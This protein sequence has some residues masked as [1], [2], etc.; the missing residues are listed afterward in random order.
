MK[1]RA[2]AK[3]NLAL[4][5]ISKDNTGYHLIKTVYQQ[6]PL[7]D[8]IE[9]EKCEKDIGEICFK[10]SEKELIDK[11]NNTVKS[12]IDLMRKRY[13]IPHSYSVNIIKNIPVGS[14]LGGGSSNAASII[15]SINEI[16]NLGLNKNILEK[17]ASEIGMD[18]PFFIEGETALGT[19]YGEK[20][21]N[22]PFLNSFP[23]WNKMYK[24]LLIPHKR[25]S[26]K[27]IYEKVDMLISSG[28]KKYNFGKDISK[29][30]EMIEAF[31]QKNFSSIMKNIHNDFEILEY[32]NLKK[33]SSIVERTLLCGSGSAIMGF[34]KNPFDVKALSLELPNLRILNL[35]P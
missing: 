32:E 16:E 22:L 11:D 24:I 21:Q 33:L 31:S 1:F 29:T 2:Y 35:T 9:I 4:D 20:I 3:I 26:T 18:V 25:K 34:S 7:F 30:N 27:D 5:I 12:A 13:K 8:E 10:E 14:G 19:H 15:K 17:L 23:E 28:D 6:I